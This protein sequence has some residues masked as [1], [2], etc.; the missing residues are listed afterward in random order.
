MADAVNA[1][2]ERQA[3]AAPEDG[4]NFTPI[5]KEVTKAEPDVKVENN[6]KA[7]SASPVPDG[8]EQAQPAEPT[9]V[10]PATPSKKAAKPKKAATPKA[11]KE[12]KTPK[13]KGTPAKRAADGEATPKSA[14]KAKATPGDRKTIPTSVAE[15]KEEDKMLMKWKWVSALQI[16]RTSPH[17]H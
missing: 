4:S 7:D 11:P 1:T 15:M 17:S 13:A 9:A 8:P 6:D 5:N 14:K 3:S 2:P 10:E 16:Y 12:P